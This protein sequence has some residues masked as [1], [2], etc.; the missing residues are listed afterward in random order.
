[1]VELIVSDELQ[2]TMLEMMLMSEDIDFNVSTNQQ[3][4]MAT[5]YLIVD[6]VP[7]DEERSVKWIKE[8]QNEN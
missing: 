2:L 7:L 8:R 5:P 3:Y 4:D 1:M 6:G